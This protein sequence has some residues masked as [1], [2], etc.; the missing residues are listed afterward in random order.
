MSVCWTL[1]LTPQAKIASW[2]G[3]LRTTLWSRTLRVLAG[4]SGLS[5]QWLQL[6]TQDS[7][8]QRSTLKTVLEKESFCLMNCALCQKYPGLV[9]LT[10]LFV[11]VNRVDCTYSAFKASQLKSQKWQTLG[12]TSWRNER[13]QRQDA[14]AG[15][16]AWLHVSRTFRTN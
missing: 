12:L 14:L 3:T 15:I 5:G 1:P 7:R 16:P 8:V 6:S 10:L 9:C 13:W 4:L 2:F 11:A